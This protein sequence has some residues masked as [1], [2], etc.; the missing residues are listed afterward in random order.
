MK[1]K[2]LYEGFAPEKQAEYE[3]S[4]LGALVRLHPHSATR[5][6]QKAVAAESGFERLSLHNGDC[7]VS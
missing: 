6:L 7:F 5:R 2:D 3:A 1:D 4:I